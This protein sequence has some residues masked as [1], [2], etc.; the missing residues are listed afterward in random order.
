MVE[1]CGLGSQV[2]ETGCQGFETHV[3]G[4]VMCV[5]WSKRVAGVQRRTKNKT[6]KHAY[7]C[8]EGAKMMVGGQKCMVGVEN[9]CWGLKTRAG[10]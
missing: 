7:A 4:F 9:M 1:M 2:A 8:P 6:W 5:C 3:W 10:G